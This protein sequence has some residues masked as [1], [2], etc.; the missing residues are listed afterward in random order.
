MQQLSDYKPMESISLPG[1]GSLQCS[2][3]ILVVGPNSS[4]KSHLLQDIYL[5]LTGQPR[6][7]VVLTDIRIVKPP[8]YEPFMHRLESEGYIRDHANDNGT[9]EWKP[10]TTFAG[11]PQSK[12]EAIPAP[13]AKQRY[14][15]YVP[16]SDPSSRQGNDYLGY[17]GKYIVSGLFLQQRL[18]PFPSVT[19]IDYQTEDPTDDMHSLVLND[20]AR[21]SLWDETLRT[22]EK[23][24]WPDIT[25]GKQVGLKVSDADN[26]PTYEELNSPAKMRQY[27]SLDTEGDGFKS[28]VTVCMALLLGHRPVCLVD[29]PE[30]CLHP[31]QA[32]NLGQFIGRR[33][34]SPS[35]VTFV[36]THSSHV[37]RGAIQ[38]RENIQIVRLERRETKFVAH[39]IPTI[40]LTT[41][42]AKP[43][44]RAES[45]LDGIFAQ[46]VVVLEADGDRLVYQAVWEKLSAEFGLDVHFAT[47]GGSGGIADTCKLYRTLKIPVVVIADLDVVTTPERLGFILDAMG[48]SAGVNELVSRARSVMELIKKIPPDIELEAVRGEL[49]K[50]LPEGTTW[51]NEEDIPVQQRLSRISKQLDRM[52]RLK[53]G[54]VP[55][56]PREVA[57]LLDEL[58]RLLKNSGVFLVPVGELEWWLS[59]ANI[60][61]SKENDKWVWANEAATYITE[62][63]MEATRGD[64][65]DFMREVWGYLKAGN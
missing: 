59:A 36:A 16:V 12:I 11:A 35:T 54:G 42:L 8:A 19:A 40:A 3:L 60:R 29:E 41:A 2:G 22:F 38:S 58:L 55:R 65:W 49:A 27:A 30:M 44:V 4:G 33:G 34:A 47:V 43:T 37:L 51:K 50:I 6:S 39:I 1:V 62:V 31:P 24:V 7:L 56:L 17:F 26:L 53:S 15:E 64:V 61:A 20:S 9:H 10:R 13:L 48:A 5:R 32:Y 52:R 45:V 28:Y 46:A 57:E 25:Q 14:D 21:K 23:A 18:K 63:S